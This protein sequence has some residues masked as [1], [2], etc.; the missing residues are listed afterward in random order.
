MVPDS[1]VCAWTI[2]QGNVVRWF[3]INADITPK[4]A[5]IRF[6]SVLDSSTR[7]ADGFVILPSARHESTMTPFLFNTLAIGT[8]P[9]YLR[10]IA[11][12][13]RTDRHRNGTLRK[14]T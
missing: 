3:G 13:Q 2:E 14:P 6:W 8:I 12:A 4:G 1:F 7:S 9:A 11:K 10:E 5:T